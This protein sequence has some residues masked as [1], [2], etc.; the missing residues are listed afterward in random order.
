[1]TDFEQCEKCTAHNQ[2][3]ITLTDGLDARAHSYFSYSLARESRRHK[4]MN[5][6]N[7]E[8]ERKFQIAE[9]LKKRL[10]ERKPDKS[11]DLGSS[12]R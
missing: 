6:S 7:N 5:G 2:T 1:M 10:A 8:Y 3:F 11:S 9:R 12:E 4:F